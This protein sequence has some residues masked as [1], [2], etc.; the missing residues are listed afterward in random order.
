MHT[1]FLAPSGFGGGLNSVS[2]GLIRALERAGLK[3]GFFKPIARPRPRAFLR[4]GGAHTAY[5]FP[6]T[7]TVG[8]G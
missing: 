1:L 6:R 2:L 7:A 3:V 4:A 5:R 8:T